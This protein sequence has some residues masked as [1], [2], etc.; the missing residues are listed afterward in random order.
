MKS[1]VE[2]AGGGLDNLRMSM[3]SSQLIQKFRKAIG[4]PLKG[5]SQEIFDP[6]F[7]H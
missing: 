2:G 1:Q 6:C 5:K 4:G 7:F 3:A